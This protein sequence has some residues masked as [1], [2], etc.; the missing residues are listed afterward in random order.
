MS[1][2]TSRVLIAGGGIGGAA[3]ALAMARK[4][5]SVTLFERAAEFGE[6]GA[7]LQIGPHGARILDSWGLL[8]T[9]LQRGVLP[10]NIVFRDAVT[11]E[12]LTRVDLGADFQNRYGGPYFVIHRSDLHSLIIDAA[13]GAG[14][15][16]L[17]GQT[18]ADV[19]T[20]GDKLSLIHI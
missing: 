1:L 15:E 2:S 13:R 14:A 3:A 18:V 17:T 8:D 6:V 4:G 5:A 16:L 20:E 12:E 10:G 11:S 19:T 7:G 9:A